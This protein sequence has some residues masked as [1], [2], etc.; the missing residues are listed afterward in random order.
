MAESMEFYMSHPEFMS[1]EYDE[2][3][4]EGEEA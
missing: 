3:V 2:F 4:F 1:G